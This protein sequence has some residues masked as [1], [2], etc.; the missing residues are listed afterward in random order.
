LACRARWGGPPPL[1]G[2]GGHPEDAFD[3]ILISDHNLDVGLLIEARTRINGLAFGKNAPN[4]ID[5]WQTLGHKDAVQ[6]A[7][8]GAIEVTPKPVCAVGG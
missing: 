6:M 7:D 1:A 4:A 5:G 3:A 2:F 8:H